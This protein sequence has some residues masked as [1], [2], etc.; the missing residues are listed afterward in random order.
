MA[1]RP[2]VRL[3]TARVEALVWVM[4]YIGLFGVGVGWALQRGDV[5][6]GWGLVAAGAA[7]A[8]AGIVLIWTRSRMKPEETT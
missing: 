7:L 2:T 4:I 5:A 1:S 6:W 3:T 8:V